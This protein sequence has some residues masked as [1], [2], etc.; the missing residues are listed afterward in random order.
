M[1]KLLYNKTVLCLLVAICLAVPFHH[2]IGSVSIFIGIGLWLHAWN[3]IS[4]V[5]NTNSTRNYRQFFGY[6]YATILL[7]NLLTTYWVAYST[8]GGLAAFTLNSLFMSLVLQLF[9]WL[10]YYHASKLVKYT[11][12]VSLWLLFEWGHMNWDLSWSWLNFGNAFATNVHLVQW[13]EYTGT[14]GGTVWVWASGIALYEYYSTRQKKIIVWALPIWL[15]PVL[16]SGTLHIKETKNL[17][18]TKENCEKGIEVVIM[19][20]N[21]EP[22][23]EKFDATKNKYHLDTFLANTEKIIT[24]ATQLVIAPETN[25]ADMLEEGDLYHEKKIIDIKAFIRKHPS[26]NLITGASTYKILQDSE[27][28]TSPNKIEIGNEMWIEDY[29]TALCINADTTIQVYH[30]SKFVPGSEM[31]PFHLQSL[32]VFG[33]FI[34]KMGGASGGL[35]GQTERTNFVTDKGIK[36]APVI[37]YESVYGDFVRQFVKNGASVIAIIT[38]DGWWDGRGLGDTHFII[39]TDE[40]WDGRLLPEGFVD[41]YTPGYRQHNRYAALRAIENRRWIVRS[42][43][44]GTSSVISPMGDILQATN[45]W[46]KASITATVYPIT[47]ITLYT[48][49]GDWLGYV[50]AILLVICFVMKYKKT[51]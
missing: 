27:L 46:E 7:W 42:A 35:T 45:Y 34:S 8:L 37:C 31:I 2:S 17:D 3:V 49:Y 9:Y 44:T 28:E 19:Q 51:Y 12:L 18:K 10:F 13:Y 15:L 23:H 26:I 24:P 29:N 21:I 47:T 6:N 14:L 38:N 33:S 1:K 20:P 39:T 4:P 25:L 40:W 30:K 50:A 36:V 22:W 48:L 41:K 5:E 16:V 43:N 11:A 32:Q